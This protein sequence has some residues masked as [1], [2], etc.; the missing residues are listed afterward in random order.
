PKNVITRSLGPHPSVHIDLEGPYSA[1]S[2]DVFLICS[3]GLSGPISDEEIGVLLRC[4]AP[5][6]AA[7][8]LVDLANFRGGPDNISADIDQVNGALRK[9]AAMESV[10]D[11]PP[12]QRWPT[13]PLWVAAGAFLAM[14]AYCLVYRYWSGA[15]GAAVGFIA[16][17]AAGLIMRAP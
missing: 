3:D 12:S 11:S 15:V 10:N 16:D 4:L 6:E 8:T 17:V 2:G 1:E 9:A 14:L 13:A 7:Q 5:E